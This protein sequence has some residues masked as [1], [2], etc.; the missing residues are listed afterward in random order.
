LRAAADRSAAAPAP[1][2]GDAP[3]PSD[4]APPAAG[5]AAP[6][7]GQAG[8]GQAGAGQAGAGQAGAG[9]KTTTGVGELAP[10][11]GQAGADQAGAGEKATTGAGELAPGAD[12]AGAGEVARRRRAAAPEDAV[13]PG[14]GDDNDERGSGRRQRRQRGQRW[15]EAVGLFAIERRMLAR[16]DDGQPEQVLWDT[17][18]FD[19]AAMANP[20]AGTRLAGMVNPHSMRH[21]PGY[22]VTAIGVSLSVIALSLIVASF[23]FCRRLLHPLALTGQ[24]ALSLY[25]GHVLVGFSVLVMIGKL[26]GEDLSFIAFY[27]VACWVAAI[28]FACLWRSYFKRGPIEAVM[29]WLTG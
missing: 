9:E 6:G 18:W 1:D 27:I 14:R 13:Y 24:M 16:G 19:T 12:Q 20:T 23:A 26:S 3:G 29:R 15:P 22:M 10:G 2:Q 25:I 4:N 5:A 28:G 17:H 11:A 7:A 8:A 21:G